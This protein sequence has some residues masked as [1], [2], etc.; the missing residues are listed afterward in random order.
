MENHPIPQNVTG[1][2]FKLIGDMTV[3]QFGYLATGALFGWI[4]F[5]LPFPTLL[6][7]PLAALFT[8][9]GVS[10]AFVPVGGRPMDTMITYFL[11]AL[12]APNQFVYQKIG[13]QLIPPMLPPKKTSKPAFPDGSF[14]VARYL[15]SIPKVKSPLDQK[16]EQLLASLFTASFPPPLPP[17][18]SPSQGGPPANE[19]P[20]LPQEVQQPTILSQEE[21]K[22]TVTHAPEDITQSLAQA[23]HTIEEEI[24]EVRK[25]EQ[26]KEDVQEKARLHEAVAKLGKELQDVLSQKQQ[27]EK[28]LAELVTKLSD[29]KKGPTFVP[30]V[31]TQKVVTPNVRKIPKSMGKTVG[32]PLVPDF[33][34]LLTGVVKDS[35][36]N[37]LPNML[38]E[39]KD[40]KGNP[41]RAFKT[42]I[43]G[44]FASA[45]TLPNGTY[46]L[47]F[48][49]P[50][51]QH[52]FDTIELTLTGDIISPLE[53]VSEDA[54]E[55]LRKELFKA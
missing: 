25:E 6:R 1:F 36:G 29:D 16:E 7:L 24:E 31:A 4:V 38:V 22:A 52:L 23:A 41:V 39:V 34:N 55:Q 15:Q 30:S 48:E 2:Q 47:A 21:E 42:N 45:T 44:Q 40:T 13:G 19:E 10:L 53:V 11:Q 14:A 12:F 26:Q 35:R 17:P 3:R 51:E 27:V 28:Q 8:L 54:R 49:D 18:A 33:P 9:C 50:N 43:L 46:T 32:L 5:S 37:V 20:L